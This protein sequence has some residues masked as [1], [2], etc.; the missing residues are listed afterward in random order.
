MYVRQWRIALHG[1]SSNYDDQPGL[2]L[3]LQLGCRVCETVCEDFYAR[4]ITPRTVRDGKPVGPDDFRIK[5]DQATNWFNFSVKY[6][7]ALQRHCDQCG[8]ASII[9]PLQQDTLIAASNAAMSPKWLRKAV[10]DFS[11]ETRT[12]P[13]TS[14]DW[15]QEVYVG[16]DGITAMDWVSFEPASV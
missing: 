12:I 4:R 2:A 3:I 5:G 1:N 16:K 10:A 9:P 15:P 6:R 13:A 14:S 7:L 11:F 8:T